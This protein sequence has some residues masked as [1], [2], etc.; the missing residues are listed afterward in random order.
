MY[1]YLNL[2]KTR[3]FVLGQIRG[4]P[5]HR[6]TWMGNNDNM[7]D[8]TQWISV[9]DR[10]PDQGKHVL[11]YG[12]YDGDNSIS[13]AVASYVCM[14]SYN[15]KPLF[16]VFCD[17]CCG[18]YSANMSPTHWM[19]LPIPPQSEQT[20]NANANAAALDHDA[21]DQASFRCNNE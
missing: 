11:I 17:A 15:G 8:N 10:L 18:E 3:S 12:R 5:G 2:R 4:L 14:S 20:A 7:I 6:G 21:E 13:Y 1:F 16:V 9:K 19:E